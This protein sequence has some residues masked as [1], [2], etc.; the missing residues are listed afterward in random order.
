MYSVKKH[1]II[2][3][4]ILVVEIVGILTGMGIAQDKPH[5]F[6]PELVA[7]TNGIVAASGS[8][9]PSIGLKV[10]M[11][12]GN[13]VDAAV[14]TAAMLTITEPMCSSIGGHGIMML[15]L[16]ETDEIKCLDWGGF[17]PHKFS[18]D[19]WGTPPTE[20]DPKSPQNSIFPGTLAGW[21]E[22]LDKYGTIDLAKAL[23]PAIKYAEEGVP[24]RPLMANYIWNMAD[25]LK[26]FPEIAKIMMPGG[27]VPEASDIIKF[28][29]LANTYR[30]IAKEGSDVFYKGEIGDK[31]VKYMNENGSR[32][33]KEE[34][35]D[36]KP[37]WRDT[38]STTYRDRYEIFVPKCQVFSPVILTMF[39]IWE[40]FD[41]RKLG[42]F[43]PEYI[44]LIAEAN[45]VAI[46]NRKYYGDPD[47]SEIPYEILNS[48]DY[49]KK[50]AD[51]IDMQRVSTER[52]GETEELKEFNGTTTNIAVV[53]KDHNICIITQTIGDW[54]GSFHVV[55][56]TGIVLNNEG[57]FYDL[58]P[59]N[60]PNYPEAGKKSEHQ[61]GGAI[62]KKDGK[63]FMGVGSP[64]AFQ[65]PLAISQVIERV[66]DF[67]LTIQEA[68]DASIIF[69]TGMGKI[70]MQPPTFEEGGIP[71]WEVREKL[72][73]M[74]HEIIEFP[75]NTDVT[76]VFIHPESGMLEGGADHHGNSVTVSY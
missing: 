48:K 5:F 40:N 54:F 44:H 61:M 31:I 2:F 19:Q 74:G 28:K 55:P 8:L 3:L 37:V 43:T 26:L 51:R 41:M 7:G 6:M 65:I 68:M 32:F 56:G 76:G 34:F 1:K 62:V 67:D 66:I 49:A 63:I 42:F 70:G 64:C 46:S 22:A 25:Q 39:N 75:W 16:A 45:D 30:K 29:D 33:S 35:A 38:I 9:A 36:Y 10:L 13:A 58:K 27:S 11:D 73:E 12:G 72:W 50:V 71:G 69:H 24:V 17:L 52:I 57:T 53:D 59:L 14:T 4:L 18:I 15:Y 21:V 47:F 23:E 20:P 60:G